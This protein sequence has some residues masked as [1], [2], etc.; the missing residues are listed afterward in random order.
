MID[1]RLHSMFQKILNLTDENIGKPK[2]EV[3]YLL[4]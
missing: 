2:D 1:E 4:N 3:I